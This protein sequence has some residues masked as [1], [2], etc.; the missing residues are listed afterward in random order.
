M[1]PDRKQRLALF[2]D[3]CAHH[4]TGDEKSQ[5][6]IFL[7]RLFQAFG[8]PGSFDVGGSPEFRIKPGKEDSGGTSFADCG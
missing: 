5:A 2:V 6:Q 3:W 1:S 4:I 7:D 8:Q